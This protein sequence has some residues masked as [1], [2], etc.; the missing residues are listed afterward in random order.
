MARLFS[1]PPAQCCSASLAPLSVL[2]IPP[3][4]GFPGGAEMCTPRSAVA[5]VPTLR[6]LWGELCV[7]SI[8][9]GRAQQLSTACIPVCVP[10]RSGAE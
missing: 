8:Q 5:L 4:V 3:P 2:W 1:F 7:G 10:G 6:C 9:L